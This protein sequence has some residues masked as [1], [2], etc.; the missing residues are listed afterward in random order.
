MYPLQSLAYLTFILDRSTGQGRPLHQ[1]RPS[2]I[3][4]SC[5]NIKSSRAIH[6]QHRRCSR[7]LRAHCSNPILARQCITIQCP[8]CLTGYTAHLHELHRLHRQ[9]A[10]KR[11]LPSRRNRDLRRAFRTYVASILLVKSSTVLLLSPASTP[12]AT[13]KLAGCCSV[14]MTAIAS[15]SRP[16]LF[17]SSI[18]RVTLARWTRRSLYLSSRR[19][20]RWSH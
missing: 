16:C 4:L 19:R 10:Y 2:N 1:F 7:H 9:R 3:R 6:P 13:G 18:R 15:T 12:S 5:L 20:A 8:L 14:A 11:H 17:P